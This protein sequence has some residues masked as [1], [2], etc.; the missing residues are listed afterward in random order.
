MNDALARIADRLL[1]LRCQVGDPAAFTD[2][3]ARHHGRLHGYLRSLL[4]EVAAADAAQDVWL[5]IWRGLPS[6]RDPDAFIAWMFRI[7]RDRAFQELRHRGIPMV[8]ATDSLPACEQD[9]DDEDAEMIRAAIDRLAPA[10]R[11]VLLLKY[12]EELSYDAIASVVGVPVGTVRSRLFHAKKAMRNILQ[13]E[14]L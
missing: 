13:P 14:G 8:T 5:A 11:E 3:V 7:A 10:H 6:L 4:G 12:V 9:F 1:L 2:L